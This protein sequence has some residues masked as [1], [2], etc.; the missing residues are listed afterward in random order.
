MTLPA[1]TPSRLQVRKVACPTCG[2]P[3]GVPCRR[4]DAR[5]VAANHAERVAVRQA[6]LGRQLGWRL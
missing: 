1:L 3:P 4:K 6:F 2:A 5:G